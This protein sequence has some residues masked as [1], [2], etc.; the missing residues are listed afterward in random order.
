MKFRFALAGLMALAVIVSAPTLAAD[1]A[2]NTPR[3]GMKPQKL[4]IV[5]TSN[6][7]ETVFNVFRLANFSADSG[8]TVSIFLLGKG[9]E[10][11]NLKSRKFDITGQVKRFL[12]NGQ[13][14]MACSTCLK[15]R[16]SKGSDVC[17]LSTLQDL[18]DL[19]R[20]SDR[21]LTF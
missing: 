12:T 20:A 6:D 16:D 21:I 7:P 9:V 18:Y 19:I 8:D 4:G 15:M 11:E 17:P 3:Q 10:L 14:I 2:C 5:L 13:K 1:T